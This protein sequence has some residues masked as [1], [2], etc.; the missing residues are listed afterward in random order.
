LLRIKPND[1]DDPAQLSRLAATAHLSVEAF[2]EQF[3]H[4][5]KNDP[6]VARPPTPLFVGASG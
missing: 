6:W 4:L 2:R 5:V 3:Y 1:F